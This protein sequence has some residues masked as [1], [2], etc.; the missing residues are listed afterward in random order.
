[1]STS[2]EALCDEFY[3]NCHLTTEL[4]MPSGR[5]TLLTF[6]ERVRKRF[7]ELRRFGRR[8]DGDLI[9]EEDK[10]SE[11]GYGW[12]SLDARR[13]ASGAIRPPTLET[14]FARNRFLLEIAPSY[15]SLSPLDT[16]Y[17]EVLFGFDFNFTGNHDEV[18]A[19]ALCSG[20]ALGQLLDEPGAIPVDFEPTVVVA[21][22]PECRIQARLSVVTRTT[23]DQVRS[24]DYRNDCISVFF[25]VRRYWST[26]TEDTFADAFDR[27]CRTCE[28]MVNR[29][30][31]P[32][33]LQPIQQ[34][35]ATRG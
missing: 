6:F 18:I 19:E 15:L 5:D 35:I 2:Y 26:E 21:L 3:V 29:T 8:E 4:E 24:G 14:A 12:V 34:A 32:K 16:D 7:P 20:S 31:I 28:D 27:Q 33:I 11:G 10:T 1:M 30:V 22:D 25:G 13:M 9:L 23:A 17:L